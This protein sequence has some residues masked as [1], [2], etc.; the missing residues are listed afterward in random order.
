MPLS[1]SRRSPPGPR[2]HWLLG[3]LPERRSDPLGL[4]LRGREQYGDV[5]RYR[6][7]PLSLFQLSHPDAVKHV[8]VDNVQGYRKTFL[9]QRLRPVLGQGLLL[10]EGGVWMRQRRLAQP[11]FHRER[12][13]LLATT[14]TDVIG[15]TLRR[16]EPHLLEGRPF[17]LAAEL[18]RLA[19]ALAG[20]VLFSTDLSEAADDMRRAVA[21]G[22]EEST[23]RALSLVPAPLFLPSGGNGRLRTALRVMDRVVLGLIQQ[24][25]QGGSQAHDVLALLMEARDADTGE[26]MSDAQLRDEVMTLLLAGYETTASALAWTFYL[27]HQHPEVEARLVEE[28]ERV[29]GGRTPTFADLPR[30]SYAT[31]VFEEALR[32]YPPAWLLSRVA[33]QD[34]EVGGYTIPRGTLVV[35]VPYVIHRHPD[36]WERPDHFEPDRF[37]PEHVASRPRFAWMPFGGGQRMCI[38]HSLAFMEAQLILAMTLQRYRFRLVPGHPVEPH[39]LVT[40]RPRYGLRVTAHPAEARAVPR[41]K[42]SGSAPC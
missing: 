23:R 41:R 37:L 36:F 31:R 13:T 16:W 14:M 32:L 42:L 30:L 12:L 1:A 24:R 35:V 21:L 33:L 34:D 20:R 10:S 2:G 5:V 26:G 8:L 18:M 11:A 39:P 38:G 15:T 17:D 27:L 28:V 9:M 22:L 7:G 29:L 6:M 40:L 25:R 19:L 4:F 3:S